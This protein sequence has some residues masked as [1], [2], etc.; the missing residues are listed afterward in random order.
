MNAAPR[1]LI[2]STRFRQERETDWRK[3][4]TIVGRA[5]RQGV[6]ALDF[7]SA[8]QLAELYRQAVASLSVA[9]EISLDKSLLDYLESLCCRAYLAVYAPQETLRGLGLAI[10]CRRRAAG[11]PP[12]GPGSRP[13]GLGARAR[14]SGRPSALR[15]RLDLVQHLR[16]GRDRRRP[17]H[18]QHAQRA[19]RGAEPG[20][21]A[22]R[23]D[24]S[25]PS[26][27]TSSRTMRRFRSCRSLSASYVCRASSWSSTTA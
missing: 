9:R 23:P 24:C 7:D 5:E 8:L 11:D 20:R 2:R 25:A 17:R 15:R 4:E 6:A 12:L 3:L 19:A 10:L 1:D 22:L 16:A 21:R 27:P 13:G 18:R 14:N 26:P